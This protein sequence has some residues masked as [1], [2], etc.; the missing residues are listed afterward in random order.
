MSKISREK[1]RGKE[2]ST[3][4]LSRDFIFR[5]HI[6][7]MCSFVKSCL[8]KLWYW[9]KN[10]LIIIM[11][12]VCVINRETGIVLLKTKTSKSASAR[13]AYKPYQ[14]THDKYCEFNMC[15]VNLSTSHI[16][17]T[18]CSRVE[19]ASP[20]SI[21]ETLVSYL[22]GY[23]SPVGNTKLNPCLLLGVC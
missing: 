2:I 17:K 5:F 4:T 15:Q 11:S 22:K 18:A 1:E 23:I 14:L 10:H 19:S 9:K 3:T 12:C 20:Q 7:N 21:K 13:M 16:L 8:C 6:Y